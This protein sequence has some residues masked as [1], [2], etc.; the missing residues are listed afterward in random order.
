MF[1]TSLSWFGAVLLLFTNTKVEAQ[2]GCCPKKTV[3]SVSYTLLA[4]DFHGELPHQCL[5]DCVYTRVVES[6]SLKVG[7]S[8][9]IGKNRKNLI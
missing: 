5:N 3:G 9:K 8:L 6:K 1:L 4:S 2:E 7:K